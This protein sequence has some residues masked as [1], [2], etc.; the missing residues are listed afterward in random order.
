MN[1]DTPINHK[2]PPVEAH[3][4]LQLEGDEETVDVEAGEC[5]NQKPHLIA[6]PPRPFRRASCEPREMI[7]RGAIA[8]I[9]NGVAGSRKFVLPT[10]SRWWNVLR[11]CQSLL[12]SVSL[13]TSGRRRLWPK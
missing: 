8:L 4:T 3:V 7:Y 11:G 6:R 13:Q 1:A 5:R 9:C 12:S 10:K 2:P